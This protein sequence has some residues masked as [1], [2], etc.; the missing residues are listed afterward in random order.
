MMWNV[1][2]SDLEKI[3]VCVKTSEKF[4][5]LYLRNYLTDRDEI[6]C[7]PKAVVLISFSLK[8][9]RGLGFYDDFNFLNNV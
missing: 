7:A 8:L 9:I 6:S 3:S 4:K 2:K 1:Q 5:P